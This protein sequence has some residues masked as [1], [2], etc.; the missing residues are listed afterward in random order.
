MPKG[1]FSVDVIF[2]HLNGPLETS[3]LRMYWTDLHKIFRIGTY[4]GGHD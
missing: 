2:F 4:M 3:Y 1:L